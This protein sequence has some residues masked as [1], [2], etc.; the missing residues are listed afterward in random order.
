VGLGARTVRVP[1]SRQPDT[2]VAQRPAAGTK[3]KKGTVVRLN[4]ARAGAPSPTTTTSTSSATSAASSSATVGVPSVVG[5]QQTAA[6]RKLQRAGLRATIA[7]VASSRP[8][9]T[10]VRQTPAPGTSVRRGS[11]V[12]LSVSVGS[13]P[14]PQ[15]TVPDVTGEDESSATTRLQQAGFTVVTIDEPT[16]DPSQ[17]GI[18]LDEEPAPGS[19]AP[20]GSQVTIYVGRAS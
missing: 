18:V 16:S 20:Q 4:V 1:S 17:D 6:Q 10:V 14:K 8:A 15:T 5:L 7:Y 9:G 3:T 13:A 19:Q 12:R 11:R 2:V